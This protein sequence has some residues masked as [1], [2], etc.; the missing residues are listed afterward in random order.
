MKKNPQK[1]RQLLEEGERQALYV[2]AHD[3]AAHS[4]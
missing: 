4:A 2:A 3:A 1:I